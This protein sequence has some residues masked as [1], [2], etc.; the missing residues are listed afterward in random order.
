MEI[1]RCWCLLHLVK[2]MHWS[3]IACVYQEN[4]QKGETASV[5]PSWNSKWHF[6]FHYWDS[7]H[8]EIFMCTKTDLYMLN[9]E[10]AQK[11][12][13][14][15]CTGR[16]STTQVGALVCGGRAEAPEKP[17]GRIWSGNVKTTEQL[18]WHELPTS[19]R[20][21]LSR[22][23]VKGWASLGNGWFRWSPF[24]NTFSSGKYVEHDWKTENCKNPAKFR[25]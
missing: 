17:T 15:T 5:H 20:S 23:P 12:I 21:Q 4:S 14:T 19:F 6:C 8:Q 10:A 7:H 9:C 16:E 3:C 25:R 1:Q 11:E 24:K 2:V 18:S 22:K 13:H